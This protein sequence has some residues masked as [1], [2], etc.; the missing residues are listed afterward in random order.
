M[1]YGIDQTMS[2]IFFKI[3]I[4]H[5]ISMF[6]MKFHHTSAL[7]PELMYRCTHIRRVLQ[8]FVENG[9]KTCLIAKKNLKST[10]IICIS[11]NF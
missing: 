7:I 3:Y 1:E 5:D 4:P 6:K 2:H 9:Y 11:M 10:N 8:N